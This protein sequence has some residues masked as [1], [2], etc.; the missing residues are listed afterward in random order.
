MDGVAALASRRK[1]GDLAEMGEKLEE[2]RIK[3][4][5]GRGIE[6]VLKRSAF[7]VLLRSGWSMVEIVYGQ[8]FPFLYMSSKMLSMRVD[9]DRPWFF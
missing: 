1:E 6:E 8:S 5:A 3:E 9:I 7:E 2:I 4:T